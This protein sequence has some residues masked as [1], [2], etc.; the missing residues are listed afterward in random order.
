MTADP[1]TK[2]RRLVE[3]HGK[4]HQRFQ[5]RYR[6]MTDKLLAGLLPRL[7]AA[8]LEQLAGVGFFLG[9]D[10]LTKMAND[11]QRCEEELADLAQ[12]LGEGEEAADGEAVPQELDKLEEHLNALKPFL[13]RCFEHPRFGQLIVE[14]YGTDEYPKRFWH[15][16]YYVDRRAAQEI[17]ELCGGRSFASIRR[18]AVQALEASQVLK[19]R[20]ESLKERQRTAET[21]ARQ[22]KTLQERLQRHPGLWLA[23]ARRRLQD[24]LEAD[25]VGALEKCRTL[26]ADQAFEWR[27]SKELCKEHWDLEV[28]LLK[29][30]RE[31]LE[32]GRRGALQTALAEYDTLVE[33]FKRYEQPTTR[34]ETVDWKAFIYRDS[35]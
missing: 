34:Q 18:E 33:A 31:A 1:Q 15:L 25:P 22:R 8:T 3:E 7:D 23:S 28:R 24:L 14:G 21:V 32:S 11:R 10:L 17:E 4:R 13:K 12:K 19:Q 6:E 27:L 30:A 5:A 35:N 20:I 26:A 16:S 29:P 9:D 2:L